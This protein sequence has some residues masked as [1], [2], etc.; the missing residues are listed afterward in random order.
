MLKKHLKKIVSLVLV[1]MMAIGMSITAIAAEPYQNELEAVIDNS[2]LI[3]G[4]SL[5]TIRPRVKC[6]LRMVNFLLSTKLPSLFLK[7]LLILPVSEEL[8]FI[9]SVLEL[10]KPVAANL[11]GI[12]MLI[13]QPLLL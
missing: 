9:L 6:L 3:P 11:L 5:I 13:A 1:T 4:K 2:P 7:D 12:L 8:K 10:K